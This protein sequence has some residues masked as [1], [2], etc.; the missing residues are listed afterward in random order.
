MASAISSSVAAGT[1]VSMLQI[2]SPLR[3]DSPLPGSVVKEKAA[4]ARPGTALTPVCPEVNPLWSMAGV[5]PGTELK[6]MTTWGDAL[7]P[8]KRYWHRLGSPAPRTSD[9]RCR[10]DM[11][12]AAG[13]QDF[14][15]PSSF[16]DAG[17]AAGLLDAAAG[18]TGVELAAAGLATAELAA[19][20]AGTAG[21]LEAD[22]LAA[23]AAVVVVD[24]AVEVLALAPA[25]LLL[26]LHPLTPSTVPTRQAQAKAK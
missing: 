4:S 12:S 1:V 13:G 7:S 15:T 5:K 8:L 17:T 20:A 16:P 22:A 21:A 25:E 10:F 26:L 23:R 6:V 11:T 18:L 19:L 9:V 3:N 14:G 2:V 24:G